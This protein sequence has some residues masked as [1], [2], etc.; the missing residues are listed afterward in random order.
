M[1][2]K[3]IDLLVVLAFMC[4]IGGASSC[5]GKKETKQDHILVEQSESTAKGAPAKPQFEVDPTFQLQLT[6]VFKAYISLK[7]ALVSSDA[8]AVKNESIA[9]EQ[10]FNKVDMKLLTGAAHNDWM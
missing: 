9:T 5:S 1:K 10:Y 8:T 2:L 6:E 7:E 4:L 3:R